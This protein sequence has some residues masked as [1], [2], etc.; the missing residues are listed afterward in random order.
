MAQ[1]IL[2]ARRDDPPLGGE[3]YKAIGDDASRY[4]VIADS[5]R[6][7]DI[8]YLKQPINASGGTFQIPRVKG[9]VKGKGSVEAGVEFI[10][11]HE[12]VIHPDCPNIAKEFK[13]FSYRVDRQSGQ[14]LPIL[15]SGWD[16]AIDGGRYALEPVMRNAK[17]NWAAVG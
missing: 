10:K 13:M 7:D 14:V 11:S 12:N 3:I 8:A 4:D 6:P 16:H 2:Q 9:S 15:A 5:S 17:F 1:G